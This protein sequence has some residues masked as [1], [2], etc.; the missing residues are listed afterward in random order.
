MRQI[1]NFRLISRYNWPLDRRRNAHF[2]VGIF[3]GMNLFVASFTKEEKFSST[4]FLIFCATKVLTA[5]IAT[6]KY[7]KNQ[8]MFTKV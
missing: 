5:S 1:T 8:D 2:E 3:F 7:F 4:F 6:K